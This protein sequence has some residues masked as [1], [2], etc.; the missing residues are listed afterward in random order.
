MVGVALLV[1]GGGEK[2]VAD[3]KPAKEKKS[4]KAPIREVS[5]EEL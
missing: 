3:E 2:E 1:G 5:A 4:V